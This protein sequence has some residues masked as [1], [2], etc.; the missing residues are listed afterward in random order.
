MSGIKAKEITQKQLIR[1]LKATKN[2]KSSIRYGFILGA[3]TSISSG[4]EAGGFFASKW[5]EELKEDIGDIKLEE[6][7]DSI[8][9]FDENN[10][11]ENYT[12]IF[13]KRFEANYEE[14]YQELQ[15]HMDKARP[16]IGYSFLAQLL[17]ETSNKFVITTNFDTMTEDALFEFQK[18]KPLVLG[19]ELLSKYINPTSPSRPTIIKI[20]RDFLLNPYNKNSETC[21]LDGQ[22][23]VALAPLL[24]ENAMIVIGYG[25][26]DDSLMNYLKNI[27]VEDRKPIYWCHIE[28][29]ENLSNKIKELLTEHDYIVP[30]KGFD[31]FMLMINDDLEFDNL[32]DRENIDDSKI[33]LKAIEYA[34][35]HSKQLE[36][37]TKKDLDENEQIAIKKLLPSWWEYHLKVDDEED[38]DKQ[39]KIYLEGIE[40]FPYSYELKGAY[41]NLLWREKDKCNEAEN[42]Y[43]EAL[44]LEPNSSVNNANY[45]S[46]IWRN[47]ERHDEAEKYYLKALSLAPNDNIINGNYASFL[48]QLKKNFD[49]AER[50]YRISLALE[51]DD[52]SYNIFFNYAQ[53]LLIK[54]RKKEAKF[55]IDNAFKNNINENDILIELW[56]YRL[57]HFSEYYKEAIKE[58]DRLLEKGIKS[59]GWGFNENIAQA[60]KDGF[61]DI[62][63]L[64]NYAKRITEP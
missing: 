21:E 2:E 45:A 19:H 13:E 20:H 6:W 37:L 29:K 26:N 9:N 32:I 7:Q 1:S 43:I 18:S 60:K 31:K 36:E 50:Y 55:Y 22:W 47:N 15:G 35:E 58:L 24:K 52:P 8:E 46:F 38:I 27:K 44:E 34:K 33:V 62:E 12:K 14:G 10:L 57:A 41:A 49:E 30:I 56:F 53:L 40:A 48:F 54:S 3:G 51:H 63:L 11:A 61:K 4:I 5:Y 42:Y 64:E 17:D 23:Q 59:V 39:E 25:G 28:D 16:S